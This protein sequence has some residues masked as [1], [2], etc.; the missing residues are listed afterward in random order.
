MGK[1]AL[2]FAE[3]FIVLGLI[4][5]IQTVANFNI[6]EGAAKKP[7]PDFEVLKL[8]QI[9]SSGDDSDHIRYLR[10]S[11]NDSDLDLHAQI[12]SGHGLTEA[13]I[14]TFVDPLGQCSKFN[15]IK[16]E[17][18][19]ELD[20]PENVDNFRALLLK[21]FGIWMAVVKVSNAQDEYVF[22]W[23][24]E[25]LPS[26]AQL[27]VAVE[28][29]FLGVNKKSTTLDPAWGIGGTTL[30]YPHPLIIDR[31]EYRES[32][33]IKEPDVTLVH[34]EAFS[35]KLG[36]LSG[37]SNAGL[38]FNQLIKN[39]DATGKIRGQ[40]RQFSLREVSVSLAE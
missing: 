24:P 22:S 23:T 19:L 32:I 27:T 26:G 34:K 12:K 40:L 2:T 31:T 21:R 4:F 33:D 7:P 35:E 25:N 36:I 37:L 38:S 13:D 11:A 8:R 39:C 5:L 15:R 14:Q 16:P 30:K 18:I 28:H 1:A 3:I 17:E 29:C 9:P 20:S 10:F 6:Y